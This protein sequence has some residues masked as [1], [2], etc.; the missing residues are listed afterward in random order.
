MIGKADALFI[1]CFVF[2]IGVVVGAIAVTTE[3]VPQSKTQII[4]YNAK[5]IDKPIPRGINYICKDGKIQ[6]EICE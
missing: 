5:P 3:P 2:L 1:G 4:Y 6:K